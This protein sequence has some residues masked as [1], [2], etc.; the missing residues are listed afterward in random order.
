MSKTSDI[1]NRSYD[2]N[3]FARDLDTVLDEF[4]DLLIDK[5][6]RYGDSALNPV[7]IF[8]KADPLEQLNVRIDD[9]LS[10]MFYGGDCD[11]EDV[12]KDLTG[13]FLIQRVAE[14]R[15]ERDAA[16]RKR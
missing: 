16:K 15:A 9:K 6:K 1:T 4:R 13:Y 11:P 10:R 12:K 8:S 3:E 5:N 2:E 14:L 7:R